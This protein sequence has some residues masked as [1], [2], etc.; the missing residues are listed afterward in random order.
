MAKNIFTIM[1]LTIAI[2]LLT[3]NFCLAAMPS[4]VPAECQGRAEVSTVSGCIDCK[5]GGAD[6]TNCC[7]NLS[8]AER[9]I[10]N[11]AQ[12]ILGVAGSLTLL[13]FVISGG[14]YILSGFATLGLD[15]RADAK[16]GMLNSVLGL[17]IILAAGVILKVIINVLTT[18]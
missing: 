11:A 13:V 1:F 18:K 16:K 12:I 7:C 2:N 3:V 9:L 10:F 14:K 4:L 6:Q 17:T 15:L 5:V 8:S